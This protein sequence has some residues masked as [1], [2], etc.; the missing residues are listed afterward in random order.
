MEVVLI[1]DYGHVGHAMDVVK[2]KDG[3][4]RNYLIPQGIAVPA[5][6]GNRKMVEQMRESIQRKEA[7]KA[8]G[9][10]GIA[11]KIAGLSA[12]FAMKVKEGDDVYG[13]VAAQDIV[14][15]LSREGIEIEKGA[16]LLDEHIR[17]L[18]VHEVAIKLHRDI[19]A[20]LKIW[21]VK[22]EDKQ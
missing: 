10:N 14:D 18:G 13:S 16:V 12:T 20:T 1:K 17:K 15:F 22:E 3:F 8:A 6:V 11:A 2:V 5:T 4:A 19:V 9:A 21:M 7:E